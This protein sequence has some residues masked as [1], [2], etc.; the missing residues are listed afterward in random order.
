V[1]VEKTTTIP[2]VGQGSL[3]DVSNT[4]EENG[5]QEIEHLIYQN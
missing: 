3:L 4:L 5:R 2:A 1:R